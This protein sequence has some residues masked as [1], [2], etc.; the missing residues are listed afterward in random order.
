MLLAELWLATA[1]AFQK[2][3]VAA[4]K[5]GDGLAAALDTPTWVRALWTMRGSFSSIIGTTL[6]RAFGHK[7]S[8]PASRARRNE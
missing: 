6:C 3:F 8:N 4:I 1:L 5:R 7:R 2:G